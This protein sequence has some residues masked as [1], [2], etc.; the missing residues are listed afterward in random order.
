M[1]HDSDD[2]KS[3]L[4]KLVKED[5]N[6]DNRDDINAVELPRQNPTCTHRLSTRSQYMANISVFLKNDASE[7]PFTKSQHKEINNLLEKG[8][9]E[10]ISISDIS[11]RMRIFN[12]CF[13]DKIKN[14]GPATA[15]EKSRLVIQAYNN[16]S[17]EKILTQLPTIQQMSQRLI[18]ALTVYLPQYDLYF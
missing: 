11:S 4:I 18:L 9:F 16:H 5:T 12:S 6:D 2:S 8:A 1:L 14:K 17:K 7:P 3:D 13:V 15:F 10:V